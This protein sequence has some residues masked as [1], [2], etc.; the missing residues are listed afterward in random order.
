M[1][2]GKVE[3]KRIE[4]KINRQV[5]FAKRRNGLLKKAYELSVLCDAEIALLIFSN[6]GKLYEFCSSPSGM[7]KTIEKYR[8]HSYETMDPNQS[9]KDL[10]EKYQDYLKLKSRV[11]I[12][13]HSQ[14]HLLGEEIAGMG[15]NELEQLERQVDASLRQIRSTKAR[16][17]LDQLSDLKT[18]E[19]MLLETNRDLKR[20]L[21]END[22]TVTQ[23]LWGASSFAEHSQQQQQQQGMSSYQTNLPTQEVGFF[24]PLQGNVA[25]QMSHYNPGVTNASDSATTSQNVINGFFPGW[26][27]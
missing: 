9:A 3:L 25:W 11:E 21:E 18:K 10:Q 4:N 1:G 19:E 17:M 24:K 14:R 27:V 20:K 12:L 26:T 23:S 8:K 16:F 13:Q 22:A 7:A 5:T 15:V 6:R 2:R